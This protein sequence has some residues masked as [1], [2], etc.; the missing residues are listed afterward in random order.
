MHVGVKS[1]HHVIKADI[2]ERRWMIFM[3]K[4]IIIYHV[5]IFICVVCVGVIYMINGL[6]T[7]TGTY[8]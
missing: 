8:N 2:S 1:E 5:N 3:Q 6:S 7:L 4:K